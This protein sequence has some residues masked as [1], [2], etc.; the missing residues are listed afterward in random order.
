VPELL[1]DKYKDLLNWEKISGNRHMIVSLNFFKKHENRWVW[2]NE[3]GTCC[4]V[5][6]N[7]NSKLRWSDEFLERYKDGIWWDKITD[8]NYQ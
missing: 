1:A 3:Y 7:N 4:S 6:M 2:K 8:I 5:W